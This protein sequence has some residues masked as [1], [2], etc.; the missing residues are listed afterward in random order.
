MQRVQCL[1]SVHL[2]I[3]SFWLISNISR[4]Q[5]LGVFLEL[6]QSFLYQILF[7][8]AIAYYV[9]CTYDTCINEDS[10]F[11]L[12]LFPNKRN[13]DIGLVW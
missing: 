6:T 8:K 9:L 4:F 3:S 2:Q 1:M 7:G 13:I 11:F 12:L 10:N 5:A